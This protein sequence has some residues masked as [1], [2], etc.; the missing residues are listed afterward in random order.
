VAWRELTNLT[1]VA[2]DL[3]A[4]ALAREET[5]GAHTRQDFPATDPALR[6]RFLS[7]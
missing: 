5:R 1:T 2:Q 6:V 7:R 4:A 3:I